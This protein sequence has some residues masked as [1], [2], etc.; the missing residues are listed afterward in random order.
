MLINNLVFLA[1]MFLFSSCLS[2]LL[3]LAKTCY[4]FIVPYPSSRLFY[5]ITDQLIVSK[6]LIRLL[7]SLKYLCIIFF[8]LSD[9]YLKNYLCFNSFIAKIRQT[10]I[11]TRSRARFRVGKRRKQITYEGMDSFKKPTQ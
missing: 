10:G 11:K 4:I 2:L 5:A 1:K 8:Y 9:V 3:F 7:P 6:L